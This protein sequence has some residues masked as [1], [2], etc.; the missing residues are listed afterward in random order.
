MP[1]QISLLSIVVILAITL[2]ACHS[3]P[4]HAK[5]I[6]KNATAVLSVD[7]AGMGK[8]IAWS[9]I[10]GSKIFDEW[11][12]RP[13]QKDA[14]K[15]IDNA[16]IDFM[17]TMYV[18]V[19]SDKRFSG[20]QRITG[21]IPM[22]DADK[23]EAF[24]KKNFPQ[25]SIKDQGKRKEAMVTENMYAGWNKKLLV[26]INAKPRDSWPMDIDNTGDSTTTAPQPA[27]TL[28]AAVL[29]AEMEK[30]FSVTG[31][32]AL[33]GNRHFA[34]LQKEGHDIALWVNYDDMM[35][36]YMGKG[37]G[38]TSGLSLS[39]SLWKDAAFTSG[40]DFNKGNIVFE[41]KYYMPEELKEIGAEMGSTNVD[42][43]MV[44]KLPTENLDMISAW[45]LSPKGLKSIMEKTGVLGLANIALGSSSTN[46]DEILGAFTGDMGFVSNNLS[47]AATQTPASSD[48]GAIKMIPDFKPNIN[49]V[50]V[51]K[52]NKK[53]NFN[54]LLQ[55]AV[56]SELLQS[57]G[58]NTYTTK[59]GGPD[60]PVMMINDKYAV[61]SNKAET[62]S[63]YLSGS[64]KG[65]KLS[66]LAAES[67]TGHPFGMF[68]DVQQ[69]VKSIDPALAQAKMDPAMVAE[70]KKLV[71]NFA[72]SGGDF[73]NSAFSS[74]STLNFT[75]KEENSLIQILNFA[76]HMSDA[77]NKASIAYN[78]KMR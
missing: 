69:V 72:V 35:T 40:L 8:K 68:I 36:D 42:K 44:E 15:G 48:S 70:A 77:Q 11:K 31:E 23:F 18:Y 51:I 20:G 17:N 53:E 55:L 25:V 76:I 33:T 7:F 74:K 62:A 46:V 4:E 41:M 73:K 47:L 57:S 29:S 37:A 38:S 9:A 13:Q 59:N 30:A 10:T 61:I 54:K 58:N 12:A 1:K 56:T 67:V 14:V 6:P 63:A 24:L 60:A 71:E 3:M 45:H 64:N 52:I 16:G 32:N 22:D 75:N 43:E 66:G 26:V 50:Y 34:A 27:P 39:S 78:M 28:D 5:Y 19:Q 2:S 65:P 49:Y 21:L